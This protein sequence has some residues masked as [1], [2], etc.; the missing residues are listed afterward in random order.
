MDERG[1][2]LAENRKFGNVLTKSAETEVRA[3]YGR[4]VRPPE[5]YEP[6]TS[7][8]ANQIFSFEL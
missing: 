2:D 4:Q 3:R 6:G 5:R 8:T 7:E 1:R